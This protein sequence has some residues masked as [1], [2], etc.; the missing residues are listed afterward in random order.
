TQSYVLKDAIDG[1]SGHIASFIRGE[2]LTRVYTT[3]NRLVLVQD[4]GHE[5]KVLERPLER[6]DFL[7]GQV[8]NDLFWP[9]AR[10]NTYGELFPSLYVDASSIHSNSVHV[11]EAREEGFVAPMGQSVLL[12]PNCKGLNPVILPGEIAHRTSMI[13]LEKERGFIFKFV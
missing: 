8:L 4:T 12:P 10:M 2:E 11:I 6:F 13:C 3:Q 9:I 5:Q 7:P 1:Y